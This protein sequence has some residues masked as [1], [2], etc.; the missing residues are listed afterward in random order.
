MSVEGQ[1]FLITR[2]K[3]V[4][5]QWLILRRLL[6]QKKTLNIFRQKLDMRVLTKSEESKQLYQS[7]HYSVKLTNSP[8][9]KDFSNTFG[10]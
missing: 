1:I 6:Q 5:L 10:N 3:K 7:Q 4:R 2:S 9:S 8:G